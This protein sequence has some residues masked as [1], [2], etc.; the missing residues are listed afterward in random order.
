MR[1][2]VSLGYGLVIISHSQQKTYKDEDN[3][4]YSRIEPTID[5]RGMLVCSRLCDIIGLAK[6]SNNETGE[7]KTRLYLRG[8]PRYIAGSRFKYMPFSIDFSY[9]NLVN[10]IADAIEK[11]EQEEGAENFTNEI[12]RPN[13]EKTKYDFDSSMNEVRSIITSLME[14]DKE[15]YAPRIKEIVEK[16][17][18][19]NKKISEAERSQVEQVVVVL[20]ELKELQAEER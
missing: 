1:K 11:Q 19:K 3:K 6:P 13:Y 5:K 18:G 9:K 2:I 15:Y 10:A 12:Q 8:T 7:S 20:D 4:E 16:E 17:F 14:K